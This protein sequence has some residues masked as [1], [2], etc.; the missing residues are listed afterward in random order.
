MKRWRTPSSPTAE[1]TLTNPRSGS[2]PESST[3]N[4]SKAVYCAAIGA[5]T[6]YQL[7]TLMRFHMRMRLPAVFVS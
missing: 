5:T 7:E 3:L 2:K 6:A 4:V 1:R